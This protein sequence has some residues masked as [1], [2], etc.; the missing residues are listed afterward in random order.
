VILDGLF[1]EYDNFI[2][3]ILSWVDL[4]TVEE[5]ETLVL[6]QEEW[7]EKKMLLNNQL[8]KLT[9]SR[10]LGHLNKIKIID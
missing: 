1:E 6:S 8:F 10:V 5:I 3:S 2:T 4:Y 7:F 9:M